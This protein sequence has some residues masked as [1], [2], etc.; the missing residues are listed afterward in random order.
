MILTLLSLLISS[1][2]ASD[3]WLC[4]EESSQIR[5]STIAACGVGSG[6][7]EDEARSLAFN[8]AKQE[9][10]RVCDLSEHCHYHKIDV[11]PKRTTCE[12]FNNETK[13]YRLVLFTISQDFDDQ[14]PFTSSIKTIDSPRIAMYAG[15]DTFL[16]IKIGMSKKAVL[17]AFGKPKEIR[18]YSNLTSLVYS[19]DMCKVGE[20]ECVVDLYNNKVTN[21]IDIKNRYLN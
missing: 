14:N 9:F 5:G 4:K 20:H 19:D 18:Q 12:S 21:I 16:P 8:A 13:C 7:T 17:K 2:H 3:Q 1:S 15:I 6:I 10:K 11:E